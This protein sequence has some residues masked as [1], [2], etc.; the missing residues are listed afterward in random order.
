M[1]TGISGVILC[2]VL[3]TNETIDLFEV[4]DC[5]VLRTLSVSVFFT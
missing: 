4:E 3:K 1:P 2:V 5:F